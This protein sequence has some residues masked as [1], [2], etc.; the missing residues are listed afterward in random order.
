MKIVVTFS[1]KARNIWNNKINI[2]FHQLFTKIT[3]ALKIVLSLYKCSQAVKHNNNN[4]NMETKIMRW[5]IL[6]P[7][8][9]LFQVF[10]FEKNINLS[11]FL[12]MHTLILF[13]RCISFSTLI[14]FFG[15]F[16]LIEQNY[17]FII[18]VK[19]SSK[20]NRQSVSLYVVKILLYGA[21]LL[22]EYDEYTSTLQGYS[23]NNINKQ[24]L[25]CVTPSIP[26][27]TFCL[28]QYK[29]S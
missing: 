29:L 8:K 2:L 16:G 5:N 7:D 9:K 10:F 25:Y 13:L 14:F 24:L 3:R 21:H 26:A 1:S 22:I 6:F 11:F 23:S 15:N 20:F 19:Y 18:E 4:N 27:L 17:F 12:V 28:H